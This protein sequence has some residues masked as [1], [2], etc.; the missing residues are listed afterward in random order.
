MPEAT[1]HRSGWRPFFRK[2]LRWTGRIIG[3]ATLILLV[4]VMIPLEPTV[5][6]IEARP[7]TEYWAMS[8]GY[9]IAYTRVAADLPAGEAEKAPIVFLHGGP[10]GYVF[11][12]AIE[13]VGR[14]A[15]TGREVYL[16]DQVGSGL[17][18]RLPKPKD[19]SFL[20]HVS[21]LREIVTEKIPAERVVLIGQSYGGQ[22]VSYFL[23]HHPE[24]VERAVLSSPGR[25][26][27]VLFDEDGRWENRTRYPVPDS[28][29]FRDPPDVSDEMKVRSWPPRAIATVALAT[30]LNVKLMPDAE[31]D[32]A[33]NTISRKLK[34]GLVC[35]RADLPEETIDGM[36]M[37]AHGWSGWFGDVEDWRPGLRNSPVSTLVVQGQCDSF[38]YASTYEH[39]ALLPNGKYHFIEGA[40]HVIWW[41]RPDAFVDAIARFLESDRGAEDD[42]VGAMSGRRHLGP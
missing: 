22:L 28:L 25:I 21:D 8:E 19:Y 36:G 42:V 16:Y 23:A 7:S 6:A 38:P 30:T 9:R 10:G 3:V 32:A 40:G 34:P 31:A 11:D 1:E 12:S 17:S 4:V 20:G 39:A 15:E 35:D 37:Y 27:P 26:Q 5:P 13:T 24:L 41:E 29:R 33:L 18:D 2:A 14:L